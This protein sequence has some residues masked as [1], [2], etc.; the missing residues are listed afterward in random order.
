MASVCGDQVHLPFD[1]AR[2]FPRGK[3]YPRE[4]NISVISRR[5]ICALIAWLEWKYQSQIVSEL[6]PLWKHWFPRGSC[7]PQ[8]SI[9]RPPCLSRQR[10]VISPRAEIIVSKY[11]D[12]LVCISRFK[13]LPRRGLFDW[14]NIADRSYRSRVLAWCLKL[15][16][17]ST[18]VYPHEY[19]SSIQFEM[20]GIITN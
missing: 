1:Q 12:T 8:K 6:T 15:S 5:N 4:R 7:D 2:K 17:S 13:S 14:E 11:F 20:P 9:W 3:D 19:A 10:V 16:S 18:K